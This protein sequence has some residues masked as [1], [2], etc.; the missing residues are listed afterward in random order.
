MTKKRFYSESEL[1]F[2]EHP[3]HGGPFKDL[4]G[5]KFNRLFIIGFA[6][7]HGRNGTWFCKCDCAKILALPTARLT[8]GQTKSC[9]CW[10]KE[11]VS[12]R[13]TTHGHSTING[14]SGAYGSWNAMIS[15]CN[16]KGDQAYNKYGGSGVK[17]CDRWLKFENFLADMGH[18]PDGKT[19]DRIENSKGYSKSNC[20]WATKTEQANNRRKNRL[21]EFS[22]KIQ[23]LS[24][25]SKEKGIP[26]ST[27]SGR[28]SKGWPIEKAL[29]ISIKQ[30]ESGNAQKCPFKK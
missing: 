9:G 29:T 6:G 21:L 13:M 12:K 1:V 3:N 14:K 19:L 28:L 11:E 17:V 8:S 7:V 26:T 10:A 23:S 27:L 24:Q 20:R 22:G 2:S 30:H 15:R 25:W 5:K 16:C 4:T 18:R